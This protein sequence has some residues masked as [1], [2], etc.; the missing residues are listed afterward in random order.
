MPSIEQLDAILA[1]V[2]RNQQQ[3]ADLLHWVAQF[4]V[5]VPR[6]VADDFAQVY[7]LVEVEEL[8]GGS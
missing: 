8:Q 4:A 1:E 6:A 7:A 2:D 5:K 3:V